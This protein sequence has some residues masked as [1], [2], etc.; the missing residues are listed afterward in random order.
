VGGVQS[1]ERDGYHTQVYNTPV[2]LQDP[3][4]GPLLQE[5]AEIATPAPVLCE[6]VSVHHAA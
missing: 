6:V 2:H 1:S 5:L 3:E 4:A